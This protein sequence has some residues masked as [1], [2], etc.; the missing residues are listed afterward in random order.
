MTQHTSIELL[1]VNLTQH[2]PTKAEA[3]V[4][5][6]LRVRG[7]KK[8]KQKNEAKMISLLTTMIINMEQPKREEKMEKLPRLTAES[9]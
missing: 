9:R 8:R 2:T 6:R 4:L 5:Q 7:N 3:V 1:R